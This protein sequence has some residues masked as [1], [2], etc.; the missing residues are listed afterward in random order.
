MFI[1]GGLIEQEGAPMEPALVIKVPV[2]QPIFVASEVMPEFKG[3]LKKMYKSLGQNLK[4]PQLATRNGIE[5]KVIVS[6]VVEKDGQISGIK[7]LKGIGFDCDKEAARVI[8]KM[9][10]WSPGFQNGSPV[11]VSYTIPLSFQIN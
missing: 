5:G 7:I 9:P 3:G 1:Q 11:R 10:K 6:F 2:E 8:Q 4:Y